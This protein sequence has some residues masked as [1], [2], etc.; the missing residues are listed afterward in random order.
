MTTTFPPELAAAPPLGVGRTWEEQPVGFSFRTAARTITEADLA[1]FVNVTGFNGPLFYDI[2]RAE[3]AGY[4][5]R[6]VPGLLTLAFAEGLV[7]QTNVMHGT[8]L[9]FLGLDLEV[10]APVHVGDTIEVVVEVIESRSTSK[11]GRGF[12]RSRN[13]VLNQDGALALVYT[14]SRLQRGAVEE[15]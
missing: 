14:P 13:Y 6:L 11:A 10:V 5:G 9:A 3:V 1:T 12:V 4:R 8:G 7:L 15:H 2:R